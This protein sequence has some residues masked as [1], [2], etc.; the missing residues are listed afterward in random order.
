MKYC[1]ASEL[2]PRLVKPPNA[3]AFKGRIYMS[4]DVLRALAAFDRQYPDESLF[5]A[6]PRQRMSW[7]ENRACL[8]A[9][10]HEGKYY[11]PKEILFRM[12]NA[13]KL[14]FNG[15]PVETNRVLS[16]LGFCIVDKPD[17]ATWKRLR[18]KK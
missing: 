8:Y 9:L 10:L 3:V 1:D 15:G 14:D 18:N 17:L 4:E 11:P 12:S 7:L 13:E 5:T 16:G 2:M 6:S